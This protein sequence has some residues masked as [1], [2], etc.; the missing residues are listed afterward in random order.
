AR[1][2]GQAHC[3]GGGGGSGSPTTICQVK[4]PAA[5]LASRTCTRTVWLPFGRVWLVWMAHSR[6]E[7]LSI[8]AP[9]S[10]PLTDSEA[11]GGAAPGRMSTA[12][13]VTGAPGG[14]CAFAAGTMVRTMGGAAT[15]DGLACAAAG[16]PF[17][18]AFAA[19]APGVAFVAAGPGEALAAAP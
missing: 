14:T 3:A 11:E 13:R 16:A 1:T 7:R 6:G 2:I 5:P 15:V 4:P 17:G 18:V 19:A 12:E 10:A 9:V 8:C